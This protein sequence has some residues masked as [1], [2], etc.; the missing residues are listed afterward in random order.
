MVF[1]AGSSTHRYTM[2]DNQDRKTLDTLPSDKDW[3]FPESTR[4][5]GQ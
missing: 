5:F 2:T 4:M 3:F 1:G